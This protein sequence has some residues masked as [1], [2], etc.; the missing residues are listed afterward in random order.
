MIGSIDK[1]VRSVQVLAHS[2]YVGDTPVLLLS[3]LCDYSSEETT[4]LR[5]FYQFLDLI[6][7]KLLQ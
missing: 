1:G 2:F 4:K 7:F 3:C 5:P 6:Q